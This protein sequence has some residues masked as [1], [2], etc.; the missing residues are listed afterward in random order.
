M[1]SVS[2]EFERLRQPRFLNVVGNVI[3]GTVVDSVDKFISMMQLVDKFGT[4]IWFFHVTICI[5]NIQT[6]KILIFHWFCV[7]FVDSDS[8]SGVYFVDSDR[9]GGPAAVGS[10]KC[11][12]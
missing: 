7:Y 4:K 1:G 5:F 10:R 9:P 12:K 2:G 11:Q 8:Q 6:I 3:V